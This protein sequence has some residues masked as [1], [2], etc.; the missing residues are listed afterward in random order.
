MNPRVRI[1]VLAQTLYSILRCFRASFSFEL[2]IRLGVIS[3]K[4]QECLISIKF[5]SV[6][7]LLRL[8]VMVCWVL[9]CLSTSF[10]TLS[11]ILLLLSRMFLRLS[12]FLFDFVENG[13]S[14]YYHIGATFV[15]QQLI[16]SWEQ[17]RTRTQRQARRVQKFI[18]W[19]QMK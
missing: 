19:P 11:S 2:Y 17:N 5:W 9:T 10:S 18:F 3:L 4:S 15:R 16:G 8:A 7:K 6:F 13:A 1:F 14:S 12:S